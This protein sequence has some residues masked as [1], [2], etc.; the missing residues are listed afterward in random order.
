MEHFNTTEN[1]GDAADGEDPDHDFVINFL[2]RAFGGDPNLPDSDILPAIDPSGAM[3][4]ILYRKA[5]AA[6][7]LGFAVQES[8]TM[9]APWGAATGSTSLVSDDGTI[10]RYRFTRPAGTADRVHL[11]IAVT[12]P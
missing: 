11:R 8:M 5:K 12:S 10:Q 1:S 3:F 6:T 7:D 4:S 2:E 9:E